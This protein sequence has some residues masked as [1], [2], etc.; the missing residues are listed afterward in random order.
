[1]RHLLSPMVKTILRANY[2]DLAV[3]E[4][5]LRDSGLDWTVIR[6]PRL[7]DK[8]RTG[9]YRTAV[10]QNIRGGFSIPRADV[11]DLMLRAVQQPN[12]IG[13]AIGVAT[14]LLPARRAT[15]VDPAATLRS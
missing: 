1:M 13:H 14:C 15:R 12:T 10:E 8:P 5:I 9:S 4:D 2:A 3:M 11:A 7:T 6:P